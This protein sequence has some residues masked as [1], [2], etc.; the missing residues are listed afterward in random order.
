VT[1]NYPKALP[2]FCAVLGAIFVF[3][4]IYNLET[5]TE[6]FTDK[7]VESLSVAAI[8]IAAF[9]AATYFW[10]YK[11]ITG[12][13][14]FEFGAF[15]MES[16]DFREIERLTVDAGRGTKVLVVQLTSGRKIAI[17]GQMANFT[18]L[19][20]EFGNRSGRK[21]LRLV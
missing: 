21:V 7:L 20:D 16:S 6:P 1:Y 12:E 4:D 5:S 14:R 9:L 18:A 11:V 19:V 13:D 3:W 17:S 2:W 15:S 8:A 10:R